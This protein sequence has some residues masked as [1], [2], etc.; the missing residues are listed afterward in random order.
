M[1]NRS[2]IYSLEQIR[3]FD[4]LWGWRDGLIGQ[5]LQMQSTIGNGIT[6]FI[7]GCLASQTSPSPTLTINIAKGAVYQQKAVDETV[8][9]A[10]SA[11]STVVMQQGLSD[12]R[13]LTFTTGG[14]TG[15]QSQW[16]LVQVSAIQSN[17]IRVGDPNAG[18]LPYINVANPN[19]PFQGPNNSGISQ[20]TV[21]VE[22]VDFNIK[23]GTPASSNPVPPPAD[24]GYLPYL[25][26]NLTF[27][28]SSI[29]NGQILLAGEGAYSGYPA[30]P[31]FPGV[32]G[33][34]PG[35]TGSHHG[36]INGQAQKI[37]FTNG[38]E[39]QGISPLNNLPVSN[40][41]INPI[42]GIV[43]LAT[44]I[45]ITQYVNDN[46]NGFLKSWYLREIICL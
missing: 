39:I 19:Q 11:D 38:L 40:T 14:L 23:Y 31:Y 5:A 41:T 12:A 28:Q 22:G 33:Q 18:I 13:Q 2:I 35:G 17:S 3:A 8:Y 1:A 25:L 46:P 24:S 27:G 7:T 9:G 43:T 34:I 30:A 26:I 16:A 32:I 36:G 29:S 20:N 4:T 10:L 21:R 42:A 44:E 37:V 6:G 45:P 15:G